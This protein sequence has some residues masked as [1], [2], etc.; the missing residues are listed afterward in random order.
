[1]VEI[2]WNQNVVLRDY[3]LHTGT[4]RWQL[5][6]IH[7]ICFI[8]LF[9]ATVK[10]S[11]ICLSFEVQCVRVTCQFIVIGWKVNVQELYNS[12]NAKMSS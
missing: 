3:Y 7:K 8:L 4:M 9:S 11:V 6:T 1:V 5:H 2:G 10:V 12:G